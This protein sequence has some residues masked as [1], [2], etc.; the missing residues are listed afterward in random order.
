MFQ[1]KDKELPVLKQLERTTSEFITTKEHL[2]VLEGAHT[3][4]RC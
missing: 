3:L 4:S 1:Q 2:A